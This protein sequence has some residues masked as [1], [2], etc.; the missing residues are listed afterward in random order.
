L[1]KNI[2]KGSPDFM[3]TTSPRPNDS[4]APAHSALA[5][6]RL[7][8]IPFVA[9]QA[10]QVISLLFRSSYSIP[11]KSERETPELDSR[12][13]LRLHIPPAIYESSP[14][15]ASGLSCVW[16]LVDQ[17]AFTGRKMKD[18]PLV[19]RLAIDVDFHG[20]NP[21]RL[22]RLGPVWNRSR[23]F[24][25]AH[26]SRHTHRWQFGSSLLPGRK[27]SRPTKSKAISCFSFAKT[28]TIN[29]HLVRLFPQFGRPLRY[30]H[31]QPEVR[32]PCCRIP[33][34]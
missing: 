3:R 30:T 26:F 32:D 6:L 4:L 12:D 8:R 29:A 19:F 20:S 9:S 27:R 34:S 2:T 11:V 23:S 15:R 17:S 16:M 28:R 25:P 18:V 10:T 14:F 24:P 13:K 22:H 7:R 5:G 31:F 1:E 33:V 21:W